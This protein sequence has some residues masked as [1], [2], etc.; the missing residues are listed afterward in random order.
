MNSL[1]AT[2]ADGSGLAYFGSYR[3]IYGTSKDCKQKHHNKSAQDG[4]RAL[5]RL[6]RAPPEAAL[7]K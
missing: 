5:R 7:C 4:Q 1:H 3:L 2:L 6:V